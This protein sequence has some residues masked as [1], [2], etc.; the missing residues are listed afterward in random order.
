[1]VEQSYFKLGI[2]HRGWGIGHWGLGIGDWALGIGH[3]G[4]GYEFSVFEF[5]RSYIKPPFFKGEPLR[6]GGSPRCRKW[7][8][9]GGSYYLG[10]HTF[11]EIVA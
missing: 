6:C 10:N 11:P 7:R 3:W 5:Y 9:L 1:M 8:G 4:L 2:G